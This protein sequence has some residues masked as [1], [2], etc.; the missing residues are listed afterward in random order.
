M[1]VTFDDFKPLSVTCEW[2]YKNAFLVYDRTG[3]VIR[4]LSETFAN[5]VVQAAAPQQTAFTSDEGSF[6]VEIG[7]CRFTEG[8]FDKGERFAKH[9]KDFIGPVT[10]QLRIEVF[11]RIGLRYIARKEFKAL[12]EARANLASMQLVNLTPSKRFNS[13][14]SPTELLYRWEDEAIGAL[15]RL[16]AESIDIKVNVPPE[17]RGHV[18]TV[19]K[20]IY[21]LTLDVDYYTIAP[22]ELDQW[23]AQEWLLQKLRIVRKETDGILQ[24][25]K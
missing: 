2:R 15:F 10:R 19:D 4:D 8:G 18:S 1:Q 3:H 6:T 5:I 14:D 25:G 9:C 11:T 17:L 13:S 20:K 24:G 7:G 22:V 12:D 16:R 21:G 23:D